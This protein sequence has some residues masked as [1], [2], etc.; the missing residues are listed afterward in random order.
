MAER[1]TAQDK[2]VTAALAMIERDGWRALS[3]AH[4]ARHSNVPVET[5]YQLCPDKHAL[6]KLIGASIDI[7]ALKRMT[8]PAENTPPRDRAFD[9]VLSC[10]EAMA[11]YRPAL[12]VIH[13]ETLGDPGGW[14]EAAPILLR[15]A[16]W[17]A[18]N[19]QLPTTGLRGIATTRGIAVL[20][21]DT[22]GVWLT[23]GE[24]LSKTMAHVDRRLRM[25]ESWLGTLNR[26][27]DEKQ[28]AD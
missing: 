4:L 23:D 16:R 26:A 1:Q 28:S 20:L 14:L 12:A 25:A 15:S 18:D 13:A 21:A 5:V 22:M 9:A 19:A 7:A 8:E 24:D 6:L 17:I 11:P 3:L 27:K 10:F 2:L